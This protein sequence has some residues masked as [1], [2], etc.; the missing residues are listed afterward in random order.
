MEIKGQWHPDIWDAACEQLDAKYTRDWHAEG[1]GAYI[2][3]WFGDVPGKNLPG[4]PKGLLRPKTPCELRKL[5]VDRIPESRR[6][7][8]DVFVIDVS[9]LKKNSRP[10]SR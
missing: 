4:H 9:R 2:V 10:S 3:M 8:I 6:S 5:L 1:R 7:D